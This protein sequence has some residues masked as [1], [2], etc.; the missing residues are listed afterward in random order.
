MALHR[1]GDSWRGLEYFW[2]ALSSIPES[3]LETE[4]QA[5]VSYCLASQQDGKIDQA[6]RF[7]DEMTG[8]IPAPQG[9]RKTRLDQE[10]VFLHIISGHLAQTERAGQPICLL[11]EER[12]TYARPSEISSR[13]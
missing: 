1:L 3:S 6:I 5:D 7:L 12:N 4:A 8:K 2:I 10:L 9:I 13:D 11:T